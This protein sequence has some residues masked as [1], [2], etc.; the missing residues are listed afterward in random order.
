MLPF[1][2][3]EFFILMGLHI[4]ILWGAKFVLRD[5]AYRYVLAVLNLLYIVVLFPKPLHLLTFLVYA[6][7]MTYLNLSVFRFRKKIWGVLLLLLPL[8]FVKADIRVHYYP[9]KLSEWA[10]FAGLSYGAFRIVGHY[11]DCAP[12][13]KMPPVFS[14][15][16]FV[17]FTP[18]L[19]IGPIERFSRYVKSE[20]TGFSNITGENFSAG[21]DM[22]VKGVAF[23]YVCAE[24]V[25]RY[26]LQAFP[27]ESTA[28]VHVMSTMYAY[29]AFLFFDFAG[30]SWMA[31]GIGKMMGITVPQNFRNPF[32]AVNPQDFWQRFHISLGEWLKD[33]FF[34]PLYMAFSRAKKLKAYPLLRQNTAMLLTFGL[35]GCW[36]GF[37]ANYIISGFLFGFYSLVHNSY[38]V[39]CRKK[40][41]DIVFGSLPPLAIKFISIFIMINITAFSLYV[42]SGRAHF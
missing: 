35:M 36:N 16:N 29:Y 12:G 32:V 26:W 27:A 2:A 9:F 21:F 22:L 38:L 19:L 11:M 14:Y 23:K 42:F 5:T 7:G 18:T 39:Q 25:D 31:A 15:F 28:A 24:L 8:I 1:S 6:Y 34:T 33:Y 20:A 30:Y 10:S 37:S 17:T 4:A 40:G 41:R 3:A 13:A